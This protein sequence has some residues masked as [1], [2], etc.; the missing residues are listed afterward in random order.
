MP[1]STTGKT[2]I[3]ETLVEKIKPILIFENDIEYRDERK[4]LAFLQILHYQGSNELTKKLFSFWI[5]L[6]K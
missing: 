1:E 3:I 4:L 5:V 6:S 2:L